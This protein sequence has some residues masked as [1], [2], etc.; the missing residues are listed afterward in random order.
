VSAARSRQIIR[1]NATGDA[2]MNDTFHDEIDSVL[3]DQVRAEIA[4]LAA[5]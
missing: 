2:T 5:N 1:W 3:G 4:R